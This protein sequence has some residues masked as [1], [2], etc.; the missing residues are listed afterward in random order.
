MLIESTYRTAWGSF[1]SAGV[2]ESDLETVVALFQQPDDYLYVSAVV[3]GEDVIEVLRSSRVSEV[4]LE[5]TILLFDTQV[6][7]AEAG[8]RLRVLVG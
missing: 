3:V 7:A 6:E 1:S 8:E 5:R 4:V 2:E